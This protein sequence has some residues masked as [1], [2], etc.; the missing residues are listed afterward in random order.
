MYNRLPILRDNPSWG[1]RVFVSAIFIYGGYKLSSMYVDREH[2]KLVDS[3]YAQN[4]D[5]FRKY[6]LTGEDKY[7]Y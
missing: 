5:K 3:I 6:S 1:A 4:A 2:D 7:L